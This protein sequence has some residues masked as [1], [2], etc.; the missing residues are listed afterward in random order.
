MPCSEL[1][2][3]EQI[4]TIRKY[5]AIVNDTHKEFFLDKGLKLIDFKI[6][7]DFMTERYF[8]Q[9]KYLLIHAGSGT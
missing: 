9:T 4:E 3:E 7:S 8:W 6:E 2:T 5:A 1:A